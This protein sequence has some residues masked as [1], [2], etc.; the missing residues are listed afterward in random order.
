V[1][2]PLP[3]TA[4]KRC[5]LEIQSLSQKREQKIKPYVTPKTLGQFRISL[6]N[7]AVDVVRPNAANNFVEVQIELIVYDGPRDQ[8]MWSLSHLWRPA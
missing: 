6:G 8:V 5:A 1:F 7:I 3:T 2:H 4:H